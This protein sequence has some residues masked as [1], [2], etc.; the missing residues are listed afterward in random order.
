MARRASRILPAYYLVVVPFTLYLLLTQGTL[1][2]SLVWNVTL[3]YYWMRSSGAF[4][5]Y[6]AGAMTFYAV[7]PA[8]FRRLRRARSREGFTAVA[9]LAGLALC[10]LLT[11]EG[12]WYV[13]DFFY[14]VPVFFLGLLL[15][16]YVLEERRLTRRALA[17]WGAALALGAGY[18]W[19]SLTRDWVGWP[20]HFPECHLFLFTTVPM[21]LILCLCFDRLPLGWLR[22]GL[23][24]VGENSLEIYLLNVSLFAQTEPLRRLVRFGPS[25]RL[26][27]L[28]MFAANIALGILIHKLVEGLRGR[29]QTSGAK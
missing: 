24:L 22:R 14:R 12:Y 3:L 6:V 23:R 16:F 27:F 4:N 17:F 1:W 13:M 28:V 5:W 9:V 19:V 11:H 26:Y 25:N 18:L 7:T 8:C 15:G 20:V 21:C 29:F 2:S 10:Q